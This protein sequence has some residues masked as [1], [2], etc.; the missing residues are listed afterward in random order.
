[1]ALSRAQTNPEYVVLEDSGRGNETRA[2]TIPCLAT[3]R[4]D[5]ARLS[6]SLVASSR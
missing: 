3:S 4:G 5:F 6:H 1:M 2:L